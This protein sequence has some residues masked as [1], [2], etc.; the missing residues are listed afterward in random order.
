MLILPNPAIVL[1]LLGAAV[2]SQ[3]HVVAWGAWKQVALASG[4]QT[5]IRPLVIDGRVKEY[6]IGEPHQITETLSVARRVIRL[7][8]ALPNEPAKHPEWVWQLDGWIS[9]N[10]GT[11]HI[12][13]LKLPE[14]ESHSSEASWFQDYAAYCGATEDG[15]LRHMVIFQLGRRTPVLRKELHGHSCPAPAWERDPTRVTFEPA[16]GSKV[17]FAIHDGSA[18][19]QSR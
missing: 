2:V 8:N 13:E 4:Q 6:A 9:I 15:N 14:F 12:S 19:L 17:S 7:N 5:K 16:G 3:G 1:L 18:E 10:S 11:G